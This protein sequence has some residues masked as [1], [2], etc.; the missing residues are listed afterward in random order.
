MVSLNPCIVTGNMDIQVNTPVIEFW[1]HPWL[2]HEK[3][4]VTET[5][6]LLYYLRN[7]EKYSVDSTVTMTSQGMSSRELR[8]RNTELHRCCYSKTW[9]SQVALVVKNPPASSGD[10]RDG[11][12]VLGSGRSPGGGLGNPLQDSCLQNPWTEEPGE[13]RG[14]QRAGH[15]W[16]NWTKYKLKNIY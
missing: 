4:Q 2:T 10:M 3:L 8:A 5:L 15:N 1:L 7:G 13:S 12:L 6:R 16:S 14:S 11:G 9:A